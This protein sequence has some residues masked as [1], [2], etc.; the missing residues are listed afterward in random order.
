M[1]RRTLDLVFSVGGLVVAVLVL[2]LGLVLQSQANFADDYV[3]DQLTEQKIT[4]TPEAGLS[5]EEKEASC[6]VEYAGQPLTT[7]K[8]AEC[9]ANEY[10]GLH[11]AEINDGKTYSQTSGESR[12]PDAPRREPGGA[13]GA[14]YAPALALCGTESFERRCRERFG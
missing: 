4:F 8:Q 2:V 1:K 9:Y 7:G 14:E 12:T 10:I 13:G 3:T 6:L 5:E 11:L